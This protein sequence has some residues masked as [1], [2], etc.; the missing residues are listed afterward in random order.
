LPRGG[1]AVIDH[2]EL[3]EKLEERGHDR[4]SRIRGGA[5]RARAGGARRFALPRCH[6]LL[7][8]R[9]ILCS[10]PSR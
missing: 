10:A 7:Y 2:R 6:A 3:W 5:A 1:I 9:R 4:R 8:G